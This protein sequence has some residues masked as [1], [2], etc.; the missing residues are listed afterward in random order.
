MRTSPLKNRSARWA[1]TT[2][3]HLSAAAI[4]AIVACVDPAPAPDVTAPQQAQ[5]VPCPPVL[6]AS[7]IATCT[8]EDP[9]GVVV[10]VCAMRDAAVAC[11][12]PCDVACAAPGETLQIDVGTD[13]QPLCYCG[14]PF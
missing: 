6:P 14:S 10:G 3:R 8:G 13:G 5:F 12:L 9:D 2:L 11:I 1:T 7:G 4:V